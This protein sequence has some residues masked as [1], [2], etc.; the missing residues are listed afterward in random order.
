MRLRQSDPFC[1]MLWQCFS[2]QYGYDE[3]VGGYPG[4]AHLH[5][6]PVGGASHRSNGHSV[7]PTVRAK[8]DSPHEE[9]VA[10]SWCCLSSWRARNRSRG[11]SIGCPLS[12]A[13]AHVSKRSQVQTHP[14]SDPAVFISPG[15]FW[16]R[17]IAPNRRL[18]LVFLAAQ[19]AAKLEM[20]SSPQF[21][22]ED[23]F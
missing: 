12:R 5:L 7:R 9:I 16:R 10:F 8:R 6:P 18:A 3:A 22:H 15:I 1:G 14:V 21:S 4:S 13:G 2:R 11:F 17:I 20:A 23:H 19:F